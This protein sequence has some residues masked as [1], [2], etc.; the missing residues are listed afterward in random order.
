LMPTCTHTKCIIHLKL[1]TA[2]RPLCFANLCKESAIYHIANY[3]VLSVCDTQSK[4]LRCVLSLTSLTA[5]EC[6]D[7]LITTAA[8]NLVRSFSINAHTCNMVSN[9]PPARSKAKKPVLAVCVAHT[10]PASPYL[11]LVVSCCAEHLAL[12]G[13]DSC[14]TV[15]HACE[16]TAQCLNTQ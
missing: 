8:H 13:R 6:T 12:L 10:S 9:L 14:V 16:H 7:T 1:G 2:V 15:D 11:C 3:Q 5:A 4:C